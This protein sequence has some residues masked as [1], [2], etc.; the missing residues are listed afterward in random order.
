MATYYEFRFLTQKIFCSYVQYKPDKMKYKIDT[1][2][3]CCPL[4][5]SKFEIILT[6][7]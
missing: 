5:Y 1:Y 3:S 4:Q 2:F 6:E 7:V